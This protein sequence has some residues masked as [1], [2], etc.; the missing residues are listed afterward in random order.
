M[1]GEVSAGRGLTDH[2]LYSRNYTF[3]GELIHLDLGYMK[4]TEEREIKVAL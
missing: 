3:T 2:I 4:V 1:A